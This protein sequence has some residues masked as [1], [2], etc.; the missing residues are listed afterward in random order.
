MCDTT[1]L[2]ATAYLPP[3]SYISQLIGSPH[4][5]IEHKETFPKQT[6]RNRANILT[7]NGILP[8]YVPVIRPHG[9]HTT[10]DEIE[11]SYTEPWNIKHWRAIVSAYNASPYFLYYRDGF[12]KILLTKHQKLVDLN[13]QLT[14]QVLKIL[15]IECEIHHTAD[16]LPYEGHKNDYRYYSN[17]KRKTST[18]SFPPYSQVFIDKIPF[19]SDLSIIDLLFNLGPESKQYL[20]RLHF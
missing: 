20:E 2:F 7:A 16:F 4:I 17:A 11:I 18:P 3:I 14:M 10:T 8:L 1:K 19:A 13:E 5:N 15:K 6:Y 12:E 9:N